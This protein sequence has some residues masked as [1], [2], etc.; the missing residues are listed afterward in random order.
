MLKLIRSHLKITLFAHMESNMTYT[1]KIF[2]DSLKLLAEFR[3][4]FW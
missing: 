3:K 1:A 2:E 4:K